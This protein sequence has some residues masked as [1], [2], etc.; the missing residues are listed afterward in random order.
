MEVDV[1]DEENQDET[2]Q[3]DD[4]M[5]MHFEPYTTLSR[6][7]D[8]ETDRE[9]RARLAATDDLDSDNDAYDTL[10]ANQRRFLGTSI[11][12]PLP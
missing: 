12:I 11:S 1:E 10:D 9:R 5:M 6:M 2:E 4:M 8:A 7:P 3:D